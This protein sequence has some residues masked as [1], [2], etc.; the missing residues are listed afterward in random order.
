MNAASQLVLILWKIISIATYRL[1]YT[2]PKR[3]LSNF[4]IYNFVICNH[5]ISTREMTLT[6]ALYQQR[7]H[8][9]LETNILTMFM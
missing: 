1:S 2:N 5:L 8:L 6:V 7:R 9:C 3:R 4:V